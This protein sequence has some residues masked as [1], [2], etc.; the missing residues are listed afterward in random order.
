MGSLAG[1]GIIELLQLAQVHFVACCRNACECDSR[2]ED[3]Q[4]F[5]R[6]P[7]TSGGT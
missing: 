1:S 7:G 5:Y 4:R 2:R 3:V 6:T